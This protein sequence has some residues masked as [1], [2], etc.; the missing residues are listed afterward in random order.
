[1]MSICFENQLRILED[2]AKRKVGLTDGH[3]PLCVRSV[4]VKNAW[5][6]QNLLRREG[7]GGGGYVAF[8]SQ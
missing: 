1:M 2:S 6:V 7:A 5:N 4:S 3:D 8:I